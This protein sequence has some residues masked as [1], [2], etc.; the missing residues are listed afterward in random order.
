MVSGISASAVVAFAVASLGA[1]ALLTVVS[2]RHKGDVGRGVARLRRLSAGSR[3]RAGPGGGGI[4]RFLS[5]AGAKLLPSPER[6][7]RQEARLGRAGLYSPGALQILLGAKLILGL[8]LP[9]VGVLVLALLVPLSPDRA[10]LVAAVL[11]GVGVVAPGAWLDQ[12][13]RAFQGALRRGVPDALDL[14]VLCVEGGGSLASAVQ[15]VTEDL[16]S[17]HPVLAAEMNIVQREMQMGLS[18]GESFKRFAERCGLDEVKELSAVLLQSERYGAGVAKALRVHA[19][20]CRQDRQQRAEEMAQKASVKILFPTLLCIFPAVFIVLLG[21]AAYQMS[22]L[23][24][25]AR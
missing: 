24:S 3:E 12:R 1:F 4:G 11:G 8:G 22:N 7:A 15:R 6:R 18:A 5:R 20:T 13:T 19:D 25:K 17:A 21:P 10:L 14:I 16:E 9:L 23:L 2:L